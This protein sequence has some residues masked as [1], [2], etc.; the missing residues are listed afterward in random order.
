MTP[1]IDRTTRRSSYSV[2]LELRGRRGGFSLMEVI[3]ATAILLGSVVVLAELAG[4]GRRQ[5]EKAQTLAEAQQLCEQTLNEVLI[6]LRP[7]EPL[8]Q[9]PLLPAEPPLGVD[10]EFEAFD[11]L[12][13]SSEPFPIED[14]DKLADPVTDT[15]PTQAAEWVHSLRLTPLEER[16][17]IA[18]LTVIVEQPPE[19]ST[20]PIR[21]E[22]SRW[23]D[24]PTAVATDDGFRPEPSAGF[25]G[26]GGA[27]R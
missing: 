24:D 17:G 20:R 13:D 27:I 11:E 12:A 25:T 19:S 18:V 5:S 6:G 10:L 22:L 4:L 21:F 8:E 26:V 23:I 14:E 1:N 16:P 15:D 9:E 3:L 7:L 2:P